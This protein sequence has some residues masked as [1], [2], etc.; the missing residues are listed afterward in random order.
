MLNLKEYKKHRKSVLPEIHYQSVYED[1]VIETKQGYFTKTYVCNSDI[2]E[3]FDQVY[4]LHNCSNEDYVAAGLNKMCAELTY[5]NR[6]F[7]LTFGVAGDSY[8]SALKAFEIMDRMYFI[9]PLEFLDRM[10]LLHSMYQNDDNMM[11][12]Y[13]QFS[14]TKKTPE[15]PNEF[16]GVMK[17]FKKNKACSKD[18]ILPSMFKE[19][20]TEMEFEGNYMRLFYLKSSPRYLTKNFIEDMIYLNDA[21]FS[22]HLLPL[23]QMEIAQYVEAKFEDNKNLNESEIIQKHFF[24]A[25]V[26]ELKRSARRDEEM[27]LMTLVLAIPNDSLDELDDRLNKLTRDMENTYIVK[28]LKFQQKNAFN[29]LL[30]FCDDRLDL[31]TTVYKRKEKIGG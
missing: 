9:R 25:V 31:Q 20:Q 22:I 16:A 27:F 12:R 5:F 24:E 23:N 26:P 3:I 18:L 1:G 2:M 13:N 4:A 10:K 28:S 8:E 6:I 7:Y 19:N 11:E 29:T 14:V 15:I 17:N 30:P 21:I